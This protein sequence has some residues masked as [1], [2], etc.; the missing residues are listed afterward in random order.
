MIIIDNDGYSPGLSFITFEQALVTALRFS[1]MLACRQAHVLV[2]N[3][4]EKFISK[5]FKNCLPKMFT[6]NRLYQITF[7]YIFSFQKN[8]IACLVKVIRGP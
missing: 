4:Q 1:Q 6:V 3:R 8:E 7:K 2:R 5:I